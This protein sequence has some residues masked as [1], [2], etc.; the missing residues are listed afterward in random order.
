MP[1]REWDNSEALILD[2]L[3]QR[4]GRGYVAQQSNETR[5]I[6]SIRGPNM[7]SRLANGN[8]TDQVVVYVAK[9]SAQ[10]GIERISQRSGCCAN[11]SL[12]LHKWT[13]WLRWRERYSAVARRRTDI[14][15][16]RSGTRTEWDK[17]LEAASWSPGWRNFSPA[18]HRRYVNHFITI[19][20]YYSTVNPLLTLSIN[21]VTTVVTVALVTNSCSPIWAFIALMLSIAALVMLSFELL[22]LI[23]WSMFTWTAT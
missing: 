5:N 1:D 2:Y 9:T 13:E 18:N 20:N 14:A 8:W 15:T 23:H 7:K 22:R 3:L 16:W 21:A 4:W 19:D 17:L 11:P 6:Q 10:H 12:T